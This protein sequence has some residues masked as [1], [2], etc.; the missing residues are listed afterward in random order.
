MFQKIWGEERPTDEV[1]KMI[2]IKSR[3]K[4]RSLGMCRNGSTRRSGVPKCS[5]YRRALHAG[6]IEAE[7]DRTIGALNSMYGVPLRG[8]PFSG[9]DMFDGFVAWLRTWG[10][11]PM[12]SLVQGPCG[13]SGPPVAML[14]ETSLQGHWRCSISKQF[15]YPRRAGR[16]W[17]CVPCGAA[18]VASA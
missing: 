3:W 17:I 6:H 4:V 7:V 13:C 15:L 10:S 8:K 9:E 18:T 5:S 1:P 16:Q 14:V 12:I 11:L 2:Q